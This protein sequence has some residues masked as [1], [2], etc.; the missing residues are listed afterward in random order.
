MLQGSV[1]QSPVLSAC[2]ASVSSIPPTTKQTNKQKVHS[3]SVGSAFL[4]LQSHQVVYT[5][6]LP[7]AQERLNTQPLGAAKPN[8]ILGT[9]KV[10]Q[11]GSHRTSEHSSSH[12]A[13]TDPSPFALTAA[14]KDE[15]D[16]DS[17]S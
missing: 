3:L 11:V 6:Q 16:L 10:T 13:Y 9:H 17:P 14:V 8:V 15:A 7:G 5:L 1:G 4:P 12:V 2:L